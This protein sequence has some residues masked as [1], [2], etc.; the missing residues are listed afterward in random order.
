MAGDALPQRAGF[1]AGSR[2]LNVAA[3][4]Q[5]VELLFQ[6]MTDIRMSDMAIHT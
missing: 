4:A 1:L 6:Q 2:F 5:V 3:T